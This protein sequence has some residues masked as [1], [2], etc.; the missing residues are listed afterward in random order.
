MATVLVV[1]DSPVDRRL[2]GGLLAKH[3]DPV[4][5]SP[6]LTVLY[7][8]NGKEAL[9]VL[10]KEHPDLVLTDM[11]MPEM[12]GLELV[13]AVR[14][15]FPLVPVILMTAHGSEE[16]AIQALQR[17]AT[18]YVPKRNLA[19]DLI[20]TVEGVLSTSKSGQNRQRL[21][22]CLTQTE[23]Q[24][25]L[26]NDPAL[27][28]PLLAHLRES[29]TRMNLC[30]ET[31]LIQVSVAL[32]EALAN[33]MYHG[34]LEVASELREKSESEYQK[35]IAER[36]RQKP[37]RER[38]VYVTSKETLAEVRYTV[39][40]E[41]KGFDPKKLPDPTDPANLEKTTGRGLLLIRTFMDEVFHNDVGNQ[42]TLVKRRER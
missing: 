7:A 35:L 21:M 39:R 13:E 34:N 27:V 12:N 20:E 5:G 18:S 33:A 30:D 6:G 41:G 24:F 23:S 31:G 19:S 42:I 32:G 10:E 8:T 9:A 3:T 16:L 29:L 11:Q 40:D 28:P 25:V 22:E 14:G 1:D 2:T 4:A 15:K 26:Q 36:Q 38:R 17:G 37:Y